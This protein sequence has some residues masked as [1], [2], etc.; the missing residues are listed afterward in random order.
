MERASR[1]C[2]STL[3]LPFFLKNICMRYTSFISALEVAKR[4]NFVCEE[5]RIQR[6]SLMLFMNALVQ[7]QSR[8]GIIIGVA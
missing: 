7:E 4:C 6:G 1:V 2:L 3:C 8:D 5:S